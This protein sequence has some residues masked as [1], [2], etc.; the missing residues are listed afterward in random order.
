VVHQIV[1]LE[2]KLLKAREGHVGLAVDVI[3]T[4]DFCVDGGVE[5]DLDSECVVGT[6]V[7]YNVHVIHRKFVCRNVSTL[8][9]RAV[10]K[11]ESVV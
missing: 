5:R 3:C 11:K 8:G 6:I 7:P 9:K 1:N 2:L 4:W 10:G